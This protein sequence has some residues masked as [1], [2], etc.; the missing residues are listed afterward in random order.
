MGGIIRLLEIRG[1]ATP[2]AILNS[3]RILALDVGDKR[4]GLAVC[5]PAGVVA[6]P[7]SVYERRAQAKDIAE[8]LRIAA[9]QKAEAFLVGMPVSLDGSLGPQA[10]RTERFRQALA[11]ASAIHVL[12]ADERFTSVEADRLMQGSGVPRAKQKG[13]RDAAAAAVFLQ[14]YLDTKA[15]GA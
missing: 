1:K 12:V 9:Q 14:S 5:D 15:L 13:M 10:E 6:T 11:A 3:M 2:L 7:L 8:M 4:I